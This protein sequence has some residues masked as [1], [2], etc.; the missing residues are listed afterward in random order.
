[1]NGR[2]TKTLA[3]LLE[4]N[5]YEA[6]VAYDGEAALELAEHW[7]PD[8]AVLD[9]R[10]PGRDGYDVARALRSRL[11]HRVVLAAYSAQLTLRQ[12]DQAAASLFDLCFSKGME[13]DRMR[14]QLEQLL[15]SRGTGSLPTGGTRDGS[16]GDPAG[17]AQRH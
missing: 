9:I 1:M 13:F 11:T 14:D 4:L 16:K 10:M 3:A 15:K 6:K 17:P 5:G 2:T 12:R 7:P 8:A